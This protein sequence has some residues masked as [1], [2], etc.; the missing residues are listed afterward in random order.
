MKIAAL[1]VVG[2]IGGVAVGQGDGLDGRDHGWDFVTIGALGNAP[3]TGTD[4]FNYT[5]GRGG[6]DYAYRIARQEMRSEQLAEFF[7][8]IGELQDALFLFEPVHWGGGITGLGDSWTWDVIPPENGLLPTG[9]VSWAAAA[10]YCNW[11]HNGR[12]DG[13][14]QVQ[15]G[16]YDMRAY[17]HSLDVLDL[18]REREPGARYFLPTMD[19]WMKAVHYEPDRYGAGAGGWWVYTH[20]SDVTP[21]VG[22]PDEGGETSA[23][24]GWDQSTGVPDFDE[25]EAAWD[26]PVGAY[27][28]VL[29]PW[30]LEDTTSGGSEWFETLGRFG[31]ERERSWSGAR[32]GSTVTSTI[33]G[34]S[35]CRVDSVNDSGPGLVAEEFLSFRLASIPVSVADFAE[36]WWELT[37]ADVAAF[38]RAF[39]AG[40]GRADLAEPFGVLDGAD[41]VGF[42]AAFS[43]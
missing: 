33:D 19:E 25:I 22:Y 6:V 1:T 29:T 20:R 18:P 12:P 34:R 28:D 24:I 42:V 17:T 35:A 27:A 10:Y 15:T 2:V 32:A 41:V 7:T 23:G 38:A 9:G 43:E 16:A 37:F 39:V 4:M 8:A 36:P 21:A 5:Y 11:L 13:F 40:D 30:G 14:A 26:I 31:E 3:F